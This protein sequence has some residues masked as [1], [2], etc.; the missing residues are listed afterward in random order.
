VALKGEAGSGVV[1]GRSIMGAA[2]FC[3]PCVCLGLFLLLSW[4]L[5]MSGTAGGWGCIK[6]VY[7]LVS[8]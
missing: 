6:L 5:F 7:M 3:G 1:E 8:K 4:G 2:G